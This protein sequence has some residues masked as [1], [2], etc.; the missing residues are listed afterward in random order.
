MMEQIAHTVISIYSLA[1]AQYGSDEK[2]RIQTFP[3]RLTGSAISWFTKL[4]MSEIK[5][6]IDVAHILSSSTVY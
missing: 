1:M 5:L 6:W 2:L 3:R 4:E